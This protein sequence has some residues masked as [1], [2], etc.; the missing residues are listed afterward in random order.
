MAQNTEILQYLHDN[1]G[2][3]RAEIGAALSN[4]PSV[5]T[6]KRLIAGEVKNGHIEV[7]ERGTIPISPTASARPG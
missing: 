5:A 3:S 6:L 7:L 2:A 1:P 4:T